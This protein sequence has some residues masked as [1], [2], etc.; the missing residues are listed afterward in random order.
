MAVA[1]TERLVNLTMALLAASRFMPKSEIFRRVAGYNDPDASQEAKDRMF[2]RDKDDLRSLGIEIEVASQDPFFDD[3][4]GYRIRPERYR[5]P[6]KSFTDSELATIATALSIYSSAE[7]SRYSKN[8]MQRIRTLQEVTPESEIELSSKFALDESTLL[9][10]AAA[11]AARQTIRFQ[12]RKPGHPQAQDRTVNPMG[13]CAW[14]DSWYLV[15]EDV[16]LAEI[17]VFKLERIESSIERRGVAGEYEIPLDFAVRDYVVMFQG[18]V[19]PAIIAKVRVRRG[20]ALRL[21]NNAQATQTL[22]EEW[23]QIQVGFESE[24]VAL[25]QILWYGSDVELLAP[26][27]LRTELISR[28]EALVANHG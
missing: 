14:Q 21:R 6:P 7:L 15:G 8:L 20:R 22:D 5:M 2:E 4:P 28:L 9:E 1:K 16:E 25:S 18:Q 27:N 3:E 13:L 10:V 19:N 17:R 23:D 26:A 24:A 11:L 12:Y